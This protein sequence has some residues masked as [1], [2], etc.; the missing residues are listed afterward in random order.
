MSCINEFLSSARELG[1]SC[2]VLDPEPSRQFIAEVIGKFKPERMA[3]HLA[4]GHNSI[5]IP[6]EPNEFTYSCHLDAAPAY[7][8][9]EQRGADKDRVLILHNGKNLAKIFE[10]AFGMDILCPTNRKATFWR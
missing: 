6:L 2:S 8:F 10:N 9:F 5:A 7:V 1:L 3:G 4:I